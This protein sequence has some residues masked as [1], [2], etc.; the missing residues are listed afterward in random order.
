[1]RVP[2]AGRYH[3]WLGGSFRDR[4]RLLVDGEPVGD[5]RH[6]INNAG[7]YTP[8]GDVVLAR[9]VHRLTLDYEGPDLH[10]GSGGAQF[11]FGPLVLSRED[12]SPVSVVPASQARALCGRELDW[13]EALGAAS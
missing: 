1:M 4:M 2:A 11:G 13:I 7:Q 3:L 5:L 6:W 12:D 8:L 10:P 9:G